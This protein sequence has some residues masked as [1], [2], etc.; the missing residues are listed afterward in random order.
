MNITPA[1]HGFYKVLNARTGDA[2]SA[3]GG[4][5]SLTPFTGAEGQLWKLDQMSDSSYRIR[6]YPPGWHWPAAEKNR[7]TLSESLFVRR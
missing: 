5:T 1:G 4:G 7:V 3:E 6:R 2:L